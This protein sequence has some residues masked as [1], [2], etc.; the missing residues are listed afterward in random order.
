MKYIKGALRLIGHIAY[1]TWWILVASIVLPLYVLFVAIIGILWGISM[2]LAHIGNV[3]Y[4]ELVRLNI[5]K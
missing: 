1:A 3:Y 5:I 2:V 4:R